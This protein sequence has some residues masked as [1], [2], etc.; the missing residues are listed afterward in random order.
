MHQQDGAAH[1]NNG[2]PLVSSAG[3]LL[4]TAEG[5]PFLDMLERALCEQPSGIDDPDSHET[6]GVRWAPV[7]GSWQACCEM[8]M[9]VAVAVIVAACRQRL[10]HHALAVV[11]TS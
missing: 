4:A 3:S 7:V 9:A 8:M 10:A 11:P 6:L 5:W 2:K 1:I